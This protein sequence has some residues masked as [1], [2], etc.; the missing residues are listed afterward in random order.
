MVVLLPRGDGEPLDLLS[1]DVLAAAES[2]FSAH[3]VELALPKWDLG[4]RAELVEIL[5]G[6]GLHSIFGQGGD[7][8]ALTPRS[9]FA[10]SQVVQQANITV[11]EGG[12]EAAAATA[13]VGRT[14]SLSPPEDAVSFVADHPFA[15]AIV[16]DSTGVPLFEGVVADPA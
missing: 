13:I 12:T 1:P 4:T 11:G 2:G 14:S 7:F 5:E 10:V 15:F 8:S 6:L 3:R 16:H 9:D